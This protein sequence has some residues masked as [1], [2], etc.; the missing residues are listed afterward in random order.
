MNVRKRIV[1]PAGVARP[2]L[3]R[4]QGAPGSGSS[5]GHP[6][7][8]VGVVVTAEEIK[9]VVSSTGMWLVVREGIGGVGKITRKGDGWRIRG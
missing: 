7:E 1:T 2:T 4:N 6:Q 5:N 3:E 8:D 9:D